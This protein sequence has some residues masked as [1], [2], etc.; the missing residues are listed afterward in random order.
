MAEQNNH[1]GAACELAGRRYKLA[2]YSL[3]RML[4]GNRVH[5]STIS[6]WIA[7]RYAPAQWAVDRVQQEIL[8]QN[9]EAAAIAE[10]AKAGP[11]RKAGTRN[12]MAYNARR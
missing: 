4:F 6:N 11:G 8:R 1:F 3:A 5:K 12:I 9:A 7:G 10:A 2:P